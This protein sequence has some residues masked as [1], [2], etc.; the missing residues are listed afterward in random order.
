MFITASSIFAQVKIMDPK[1]AVDLR[2]EKC[3]LLNL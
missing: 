2:K 1:K 3:L